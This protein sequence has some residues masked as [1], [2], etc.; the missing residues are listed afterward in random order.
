MIA[1]FSLPRPR[2]LICGHPYRRL[3]RDP[4]SGAV[5]T[6]LVRFLA[7]TA[8]PAFVVVSQGDKRLRCPR[9]DLFELAYRDTLV[10]PS[11]PVQKPPTYSLDH[12]N[13]QR[14]KS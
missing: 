2:T 3:E 14:T 7:Y 10:E 12:R 5:R 8:S 1:T 9:A 13:Y 6:T 4:A 11:S